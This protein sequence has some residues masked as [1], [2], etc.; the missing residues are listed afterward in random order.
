V[1]PL[2]DCANSTVAPNPG[3]PQPALSPRLRPIDRT[4]QQALFLSLD[5]RLPPDHDVRL[6][7]AFVQPLDL[8]P[9]LT[10]VRAVA[11][12][13]GRPANDPRVLLA[14]WL[15]AT[16]RGVGSARELAR[17]CHDHIAYQWL[18]GGMTVNHRVL[19]DFRVHHVDFLD[20]LLTDCV[21][22]LLHEGL[23]QLQRVAQDGLK[24][25]ADAGA[26]S[27]RRE[28]TLQD[29]LQEARTQV[30]N[31]RNQ[32]DEDAGATSR[33]QQAARQ[34]AARE[35]QER[36]ERALAE[37]QKLQQSRAEQEKKSCRETKPEQIRASTT[38]PEARRMKMADGGTRPAYNVQLA[39]TTVGGVVVGVA[40]TNAGNDN[41]Q[42][43]PMLTQLEGRY[44][45]V[46]GEILA[47][48]GFVTVADI[49]A[50][51]AAGV[52]VYA[53]PKE[54]EKQLA[55]GKD[56][57]VA[58]KTDGPGVAA[59][60]VRMG[61]ALAQE[62][63][64]ERAATAELTNAQFRNRS[65]YRVNVRGQ[66]KVRAVALWQALAHNVRRA[67]TLWRLRTETVRAASGK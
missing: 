2:P 10:L 51:A 23:I 48:G 41:G 63:Y 11:G 26:G 35:R 4:Q 14:L 12:H 7:W 45:Q 57:Y 9:L 52:M 29:H 13:P 20:Q 22:A 17:L 38:D 55:A 31:L 37:R 5:Q 36:L 59:W 65:F 60:R 3:Q 58:K 42:L 39:T 67:N 47:D 56:P 46:P 61:T 16:S 25:R 19:S 54:V 44:G 33:R 1:T 43:Q 32:L 15:Y 62:I 6:I 64:K 30:A 66:E 21:A 8:S 49:E 34:R 50:A 40:V 27:F 28:A 24:V 18:C 53:P